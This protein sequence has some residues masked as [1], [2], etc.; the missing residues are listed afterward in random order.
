MEPISETMDDEHDPFLRNVNT[1]GTRFVALNQVLAAITQIQKFRGHYRSFKEGVMNAVENPISA[2][3][4]LAQIGD[5]PEVLGN[6]LGQTV[7][8]IRDTFVGPLQPTETF[9]VGDSVIEMAEFW[10]PTYTLKGRDYRA[11]KKYFTKKTPYSELT[12]LQKTLLDSMTLEPMQF[13]PD[14]GGVFETEEAGVK[15]MELRTQ[16]I[17]RLDKAN[18]LDKGTAKYMEQIDLKKTF[19]EDWD[20]TFIQE[21]LVNPMENPE[22]L[23]GRALTAAE[24]KASRFGN[25]QLMDDQIREIFW[26]NPELNSNQ[27]ILILQSAKDKQGN[28]ADWTEWQLKQPFDTEAR[29]K[30]PRAAFDEERMLE[31]IKIDK[32]F[33][34]WERYKGFDYDNEWMLMKSL[35]ADIA[36]QTFAD[37]VQEKGIAKEDYDEV[38]ARWDAMRAADNNVPALEQSLKRIYFRNPGA[39]DEVLMQTLKDTI[40]G[41]VDEKM[42]TDL[43]ADLRTLPESDQIMRDFFAEHP[44]WENV[45]L[46]HELQKAHTDIKFNVE[47]ANMVFDEE[48]TFAEGPKAEEAPV[49][50]TLVEELD[51]MFVGPT[52]DEQV[53][54]LKLQDTFF[55]NWQSNNTE[56]L[57]AMRRQNILKDL[58]VDERYAVEIFNEARMDLF[59]EMTVNKMVDSIDQLQFPDENAI[60]YPW[61]KPSDP[62]F[63]YDPYIQFDLEADEAGAKMSGALS[64]EPH[65]LDTYS[66]IWGGQE[67]GKGPGDVVSRPRADTRVDTTQYTDAEKLAGDRALFMEE[68]GSAPWQTWEEFTS[69]EKG[70]AF[71]EK[72]FAEWRV[73]QESG[74]VEP[75]VP[76]ITVDAPEAGAVDAAGQPTNEQ[77]VDEVQAPVIEEVPGPK[78]FD[79]VQPTPE[80]MVDAMNMVYKSGPNGPAELEGM[81]TVDNAGMVGFRGS[82]FANWLEHQGKNLAQAPMMLVVS[83]FIEAAFGP[84]VNRW[85]NI[86]MAGMD[87]LLSGD[88]TGIA[89]TA[90]MVYVGELNYQETRKTMNAFPQSD[91]GTRFGMVRGEG[92]DSD[93]WFPAY[94][95]SKKL[96]TTFSSRNTSFSMTY[97]THMVWRVTGANRMEPFFTDGHTRFFDEPDYALTDDNWAFTGEGLISNQKFQ[98]NMDPLRD[99]VFLS[100]D[101]MD[102]FFGGETAEDIATG[103]SKFVP[104]DDKYIDSKNPY[105][106]AT[107]DWRKVIGLAERYKYEDVV[108]EMGEH[109]GVNIYSASRGFRNTRGDYGKGW[110]ASHDLFHSVQDDNFDGYSDDEIR[111]YL[112]NYEP[113]NNYL[114]EQ[115]LP[116][117]IKDLVS[118]QKVAAKD[119]GYKELYGSDPWFEKWI[120]GDPDPDFL[121]PTRD[122]HDQPIYWPGKD[123]QESW[124]ARFLLPDYDLETAQ[125]A[126]EVQAQLEKIR[127]YDLP[128]TSQ[129]YLAQ[130]AI[131]RYFVNQADYRGESEAFVQAVLGETGNPATGIHS[132]LT[133]NMEG[134]S[135]GQ[136]FSADAMPWSNASDKD[137]II[138]NIQNDPI[139]FMDLNLYKNWLY[140]RNKQIPIEQAEYDS[141]VLNK[142]P[143]KAVFDDWDK[144]KPIPEEEPDKMTMDPDNPPNMIHNTDWDDWKRKKDIWESQQEEPEKTEEE[145]PDYKGPAPWIRSNLT[146]FQWWRNPLY[147]GVKEPYPDKPGSTIKPVVKPIEIK[148]EEPT[149]E[150]PIDDTGEKPP[151]GWSYQQGEWG[152][153]QDMR[154]PLQH[155]FSYVSTD[156]YNTDVVF[157]GQEIGLN[158]YYWILDQ[159]EQIDQATAQPT[160]TEET[161]QTQESQPVNQ[162]DIITNTVQPKVE[163]TPLQEYIEEVHPED[164]GDT[165]QQDLPWLAFDKFGAPTLTHNDLLHS[166]LGLGPEIKAI[167]T[168]NNVVHTAFV[169]SMVAPSFHSMKESSPGITVP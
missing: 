58:K 30:G 107:Q 10:K 47:K 148:P 75:Q 3:E 53:I 141:K 157:N 52:G 155:G 51:P 44:N 41:E 87:L 95:N 147:T 137:V 145:Q 109:A 143:W 79:A 8:Q 35:D 9:E 152:E 159:I 122:L 116:D 119:S 88:P 108:K 1:K 26:E 2:Q 98:Q 89:L 138:A 11:I 84:Q 162:H 127:N 85:F 164:I 135:L 129:H 73:Q 103:M 15:F 160:V 68:Q 76:E 64:R 61:D 25:K 50:Q 34:T 101:Q 20:L 118:S 24:E 92:A 86:G 23:V 110:G 117:L 59:Q 63:K 67:S 150:I 65:D 169:A 166:E 33:E 70:K 77:M 120:Y 16:L 81:M 128:L 4:L 154:E 46:F 28:R 56:L 105:M 78:P 69:G 104:V 167:Q 13:D 158:D 72:Q 48:R 139:N 130:K 62:N 125:T 134:F 43:W 123:A 131:T 32:T 112:R 99:W 100:D 106:Q 5:R 161:V 124:S 156:P 21:G 142:H 114:V 49:D 163:L 136:M 111:N 80:Q 74:P 71:Y 12:E 90:I 22:L 151:S 94:V 27:L 102:E 45:L 66:D 38:F 153:T 96:S 121:L 29:F 140:E 149:P 55:D 82:K 97:G 39:T 17:K 146:G 42:V 60:T 54:T 40:V 18:V 113:E 31:G 144:D 115:L 14:S 165:S 7:S 6:I 132:L 19:P 57:L 133:Q 36:K 126:D 91:R 93:K 168:Q 37:F 83:N